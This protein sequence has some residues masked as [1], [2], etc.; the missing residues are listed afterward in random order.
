MKIEIGESLFYS[1]LRHV[2]ECQIVQLNWKPSPSWTLQRGEELERFMQVSADRFPDVYK[3]NS[4]AQLLAQAEIDVIGTAQTENGLE[5]YAVDVA[6]HEAGLNYGKQS[7]T[8]TR[9]I[10]KFL[11]T[12][13]CLWGYLSVMQGELI[14]ASPKIN[15]AVLKDMQPA[16]A[17]LNDLF[18]KN[19]LRF[20][21]RLLANKDFNKHVL[22]PTLIASEGISDT[23]ELFLRSYQLVKMFENERNPEKPTFR[24]DDKP[25]TDGGQELKI[26]KIANNLLRKTLE[27][28]CVSQEELTQ[29]QTKDYSKRMFGID[30][31]LLVAA[32]TSFDRVRYYANP[33]TING[34]D[35]YLCSQWFE[36]SANNDRRLLMAWLKSKEENCNIKQ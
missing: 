6:Y 10:K 25:S 35:Y 32:N 14:F 23:T 26:G 8:V 20:K 24:P 17:D 31:P 9:V 15:D 30:F 7:E 12:A 28:G 2:K 21:A 22:R 29:L 1:W 4:L 27:S 16:V 5:V 13:L 33:L 3:N 36:T 11:R 19:N 34:A 18:A